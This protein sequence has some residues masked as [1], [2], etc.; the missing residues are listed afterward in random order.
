MTG[1]TVTLLGLTVVATR[2]HEGRN[3]TEEALREIQRRGA[4]VERIG[5]PTTADPS[6]SLASVLALPPDDSH[7]WFL[8]L[9]VARDC[10]A[11]ERLRA[12]FERSPDLGAWA[13]PGDPARSWAHYQVFQADD[14]SQAWRWHQVPLRQFPAVLLQPPLDGTWGDPHTVVY[15]HQGYL[16]P[17]ELSDGLRRAI[18]R[19][20]AKFAATRGQGGLAAPAAWSE[21]ESTAFAI[22]GRPTGSEASTDQASAS[23]A[24]ATEDDASQTG[25]WK[26]PVTPPP[27]LPS[28]PLLPNLPPEPMPSSAGLL[29][30]LLVAWLT[31]QGTGNLLL[32]AILAWQIYR[33]VARARGIPL[34]VSDE[35][36]AQLMQALRSLPPAAYPPSLSEPSQT[37]EP[38]PRRPV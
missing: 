20:V 5:P 34:L 4:L 13:D 1:L 27:R 15:L 26:P 19:Y 10:P 7:K 31:G 11:C 35:Q 14:A 16:P 6:G 17:R 2:V 38:S 29:I 21:R 36:A 12:D 9:V 30:Q 25:E 22:S 23:D 37:P 8:T 32:L 3:V 24:S 18:H 28:V 33:H